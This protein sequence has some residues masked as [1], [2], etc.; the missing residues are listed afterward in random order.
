MYLLSVSHDWEWR[1]QTH[2]F[3]YQDWYKPCVLACSSFDLNPICKN[4]AGSGREGHPRE[5]CVVV[6]WGGTRFTLEPLDTVCWLR[7]EK[8]RYLVITWRHI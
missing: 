3:M 1:G 4:I 7:D 5:M 8:Y 6:R 2:I